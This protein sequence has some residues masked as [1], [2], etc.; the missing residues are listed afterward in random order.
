MLDLT[1]LQPAQRA[2]TGCLRVLVA[3]RVFHALIEGHRNVAA[4]IRLNAHALLRSHEDAPAVEVRGECHAL[5]FDFAQARKGKYLKPAA[6][7]QD[8][9]VPVHKLVEA[10]HLSNHIV[11]GAQMQ[12]VR[13]GKLDLTAEVS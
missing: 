4:E 12:V 3:R 2:L 5:F 10:A 8:R 9:A 6:V 7:G 13:V 1:A 11:A